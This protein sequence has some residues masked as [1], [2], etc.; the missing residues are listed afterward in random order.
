[1][2][3]YTT[4][5]SVERLENTTMRL[6]IFGAGFSG[7]A[8]AARMRDDSQWNGGTSRTQLRFADLSQV[9]LEPFTF[10]GEKQSDEIIT[11]LGSVT[12]LIQSISPDE[13]GDPILRVFGTQLNRL[14]PCLEWVG[15][16]STVGVYGNHDGAW[17]DEETQCNPVSKR[18]NWRLV[19]E[20]QW[21]DFSQ[22]AGLPVAI[23]RLSGIY[24]TGRNPLIKVE[25]GTAR[26]LVK[27]DQVFNR[28]HVAD[29]AAATQHLANVNAGGIYNVTDDLPAPPQDVVTYA[30][31]LMGV[32][33]PPEIDF[34]TADLTPMARSFYGENK[35]VCN[36]KL[37]K[38]GYEFKYPDYMTALSAMI[39]EGKFR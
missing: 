35:R 7:K 16:L 17:V 10:D 9:G 33:P 19:A 38:Y 23:L 28:I 20:N 1:M 36:A 32:P 24:G 31:Q 4:L 8:I 21:F 29:I 37:K 30:C 27:P 18:S 14:M 26:R 34:D 13:R 12:H 5:R 22:D 15:Y 3:L 25:N 11:A 6:F 39:A 2:G